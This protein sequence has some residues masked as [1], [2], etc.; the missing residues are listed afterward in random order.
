MAYCRDVYVNIDVT[1]TT[2]FDSFL[3]LEFA[4]FSIREVLF[5]FLVLELLDYTYFS[6]IFCQFQEPI[7]WA[8][9]NL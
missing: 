6:I 2:S 4:V 8:P 7:K 3:F 9:V 5:L 1:M